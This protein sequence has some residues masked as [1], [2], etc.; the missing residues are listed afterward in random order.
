MESVSGP[1]VAKT[2]D[3]GCIST[4]CGKVVVNKLLHEQGHL[5]A[6]FLSWNYSLSYVE[7]KARINIYIIPFAIS[8]IRHSISRIVTYTGNTVF[9][10]LPSQRPPHNGSD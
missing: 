4:Y 8:L 6:S 1:T 3:L 10:F 2:L 5:C 7:F 9:E